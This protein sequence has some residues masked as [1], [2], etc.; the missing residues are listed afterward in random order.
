[1]LPHHG[2]CESQHLRFCGEGALLAR[3]IVHKARVKDQ[4]SVSI[5]A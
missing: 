1:V 5:L 2:A 4:L 3:A